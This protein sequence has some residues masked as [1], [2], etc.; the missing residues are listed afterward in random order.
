MKK[1]IQLLILIF[2]SFVFAQDGTLDTNF[3]SGG[4]SADKAI[5]TIALQPDGKIIIGGR[6]DFYNGIPSKYVA[7]L[8]TDGTLDPTFNVG[9]GVSSYVYALA[10]LPNGKIIIAGDFTSYNGVTANRIARL[11]ADGT[12]DTTF[13]AGGVGASLTVFAVA[14]QADGKIIIGGDF[15]TYNGVQKY[16]VARLNANGTLDTSFSTAL[17]SPGIRALSLQA[18]GKVIFAGAMPKGIARLN[19][20][21]TADT[22]FDAGTGT[23]SFV[24]ST[25]IQ[26]D[27][28]IIATGQFN[29]FNNMVVRGFVRLNADGSIDTTFNHTA[30]TGSG[31]ILA[32]VTQND[33]KIILGGTLSIDGFSIK[34]IVRLNTN[35]TVDHTFTQGTGFDEPLYCLALQNDGKILAGGAFR[36]YNGVAKKYIARLNGAALGVADFNRD[37]K[38]NIYPNPANDYLRFDLADGVQVSGF[39]VYDAL[40][41]MIDSGIPD[42]NVIDIQRYISAVYFLHLSTDKG[43]LTGTFIKN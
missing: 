30:L 35:G 23:S 31:A 3:N 42:E 26:S 33:G 19:A 41:K 25:S 5:N 9:T 24:F 10:V 4:V 36:E 2:N 39:E 40:G 27:G 1:I 20:N 8:N 12:L 32:S 43:V 14:V 34:R 29:N 38:L 16:G 21:G 6:F 17:D 37:V 11:N 7:R 15:S 18:D 13:N 28:K 22:T